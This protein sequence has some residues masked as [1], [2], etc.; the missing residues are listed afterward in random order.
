MAESFAELVEANLA[1]RNF[2]PGE[3]LS[4]QVI[5]IST[6]IVTVSA[7]LKSEALIPASQFM[8]ETGEL[9]VDIGDEVEVRLYRGCLKRARLPAGFAGG[10]ASDPRYHLP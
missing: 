7:G 10:Y 4:A 6:E 9:E 1:Q 2:R 3:I 5:D 8:D